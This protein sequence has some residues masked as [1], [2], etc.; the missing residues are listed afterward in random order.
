MLPTNEQTRSLLEA[1]KKS[2]DPITARQACKSV[3]GNEKRQHVALCEAGLQKLSSDGAAYQHPPQRL[4]ST[5]RYWHKDVLSRV[6]TQIEQIVSLNSG[7][8]TVN[9]V[10]TRIAKCDLPWFDDAVGRLMNEKR[11]YEV[12]Y[13]QARRFSTKILTADRVLTLSDLRFLET[14]VIK[15]APC[16]RTTLTVKDILSFL[17]RGAGSGLDGPDPHILTESL[18]KVWYDA[19][20]PSLL[21]ATSVPLPRTWKRYKEWCDANGTVP[22]LS[23]FHGILRRLAQDKAVEL[24]PHSRSQPIPE[25]EQKVLITGPHG[26]TI[27]FWRWTQ[28][29]DK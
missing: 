11:L 14:I 15:T 23:A 29:A 7:H 21:G 16:R 13:Q 2:P 1:V 9:Q 20:L 18:L 5:E 4:G 22:D 17:E 3:F 26:E 8:P 24:V 28:G 19:E 6:A 27:Y 12:T 10:R 25:S